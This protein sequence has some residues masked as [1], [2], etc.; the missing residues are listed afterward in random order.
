MSEL[1][2]RY[3]EGLFVLVSKE[4][5]LD[6]KEE[7]KLLQS[8]INDNPDY[9]STLD[10]A[11]LSKKEKEDLIDKTL[12]DFHPYFRYF[13]QIICKN[14][15]V[16]ELNDILQDFISLINERLGI[17]EGLVYSVSPLSEEEKQRIERSVSKSEGEKVELVNLVDISLLGGVKVLIGDK[18]YDG[19]LK[20]KLNNLKSQLLGGR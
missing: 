18:V 16:T 7:A 15:R 3:A 14:H 10:S 20:N 17:K 5:Y 12:K 1:T 19:S 11:F 8:L 2:K 9:I 4:E 13:V 6:Y